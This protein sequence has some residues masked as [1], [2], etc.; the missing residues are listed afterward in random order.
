VQRLSLRALA[1]T[2]A[3]GVGLGLFS[4]AA[5]APT[6]GA[7]TAPDVFVSRVPT[8]LLDTRGG[9]PVVPGVPRTISV[10]PV[11]PGDGVAL[12]VTAIGGD[13]GGYL[14]VFPCGTAP[15]T[16]SNVNFAA[17]QIVPNAV[18]VAVGVGAAICVAASVTVDVLVDFSGVWSAAAGFRSE[19]PRR[20]IDT[21]GNIKPGANNVIEVAGL[22]ADRA[23]F[24]NLT[25][26]DSD[27][28]GFLA[29]YPC[30]AGSPSHSN[31]NV[32]SGETRAASLLVAPDSR[33]RLC[34][35]T[36]AASHVIIDVFGSIPASLVDTTP[37]RVFDSRSH[38]AIRGGAQHAIAFDDAFQVVNVTAVN[39]RAEGF[40]TGHACDT[41][42][43]TA[44]NVNFASGS[45]SP[46]T[47]IAPRGSYCLYASAQTDLI[48]DVLARVR[49][50][51]EPPV[52]PPVPPTNAVPSADRFWTQTVSP[53]SHTATT[54]G[55]YEPTR[56]LAGF[57]TATH[58]DFWLAFDAT[59]EYLI[60]NPTEP[61][62]QWDFNKTP[63]LSDCGAIALSSYGYMFGWRWNVPNQRMEVYAYWN[64]A[65]VHHVSPGALVEF[66]RAELAA[67]QPLKYSMFADGSSYQFAIEGTVG[68]RAINAAFTSPRGC[69]T[70]NPVFVWASGLYFGGTSV[71]PQT[72]TAR[73]AE[74]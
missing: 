50:A 47:L 5:T 42:V 71:A 54:T 67:E 53:G 68:G 12:N 29:A 66:T 4:A 43:P 58:R 55:T 38:A 25:S 17:H 59:A 31:L 48:I 3:A 15:P 62:D 20:L 44:S 6:S 74:L 37:R 33:N 27:D 21:R 28:D 63:G 61:D 60:T 57:T 14:T 41:D 8:R 10:A 9:S 35:K 40:V 2:I 11:V 46:N 7:I 13:A 52:P 30:M 39:G 24:L 32:V 19:L 22:T 45:A 18:H 1:T 72:V 23:W 26:T 70:P 51:T 56:P 34:V 65:G 69:D 64:I 36:Q 16:T 73:V 49:G